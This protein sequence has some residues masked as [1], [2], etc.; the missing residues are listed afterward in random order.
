MLFH[1]SVFGRLP[2]ALVEMLSVIGLTANSAG[3]ADGVETR[4][5]RGATAF[6]TDQLE[7]LPLQR[8]GAP[9]SQYGNFFSRTTV[10]PSRHSRAVQ[11]PPA[12]QQ[13]RATAWEA[14]LTQHEVP[15]NEGARSD[16]QDAWRRSSSDL[17]SG[18]DEAVVRRGE[19]Y[20]HSSCT[21]CHDAERALS[22][23]K[24]YAGWLATIRK[25]AKIAKEED[26]DLPVREHVSIVA[27]LASLNQADDSSDSQDND[28]EDEEKSEEDSERDDK[29]SS[30]SRSRFDEA[31][32]R[33]GQQFFQSSCTQCHDAQRALSKRKSYGGWLATVR[34][35]AAREDADIPANQHV[36]IVT[37][38]A[39]LNLANQPAGEGQEGAS[40]DEAA[41]AD[42]PPFT[43]N[44][45]VSTVWRGTDKDLENKS[46]FP[47]AWVGVEWRVAG[48]PVSGRVTACTSCHGVNEGL[49]V[50]LVEASASI[51]LVHMLTRCPPSKRCPDSLEADLKAGRFIVPFGAYS[52]RV[53]PGALRT[54]SPPL[55]YNMGRRVAPSTEFQPVLNM[56]YS[57][58]GFNLHL[59]YPSPHFC[60]W[61]TT[62]D[63]YA[64]NGLQAGGPDVF[65][66]SRSYRDNNS[67]LA[68][69]GRVTIGSPIL[70]FG[71][72]VASGELQDEIAPFQHYKL[73][74]GDVTFRWDEKLRAY[75][76]YAI[77]D[78][79][80][81][82]GL[83]NVIYGNLVELE[84][85]LWDDPKIS[86]LARYD[87]LDHSGGFGEQLTERFT[88]GLN[89]GLYG[90]SLLILNHEH[91]RFADRDS[92]NIMGLR[93]TIAF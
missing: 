53:H 8:L 86:A 20:F 21:Q 35:M 75:Y 38:L 51:D 59:R 80:L 55:M 88:W 65:F 71:G 42:L 12:T 31:R 5:W 48:N 61:S 7:L 56:P 73:A 84:L 49:G 16:S 52:G 66:F 69:G 72:S 13:R 11:K 60:D 41:A 6:S 39:S 76:E 34:R 85:T 67:S 18:F 2:L 58:E 1:Q 46:F 81:F 93:W 14:Y 57:D 50:E 64:V 36:A 29:D 90:G 4:D 89:F 82:P 23:R 15:M 68:V 9:A 54:V 45:T 44:G 43:L 3:R 92:V 26:V 91:W 79:N 24:T 28:A 22:K 83:R 63:V 40:I 32:V 87:T 70:R 62:F 19:Q 47:D 77:R 30:R 74:G 17:E 33:R 37:Y 25:M 78:E 27:Y 10:N